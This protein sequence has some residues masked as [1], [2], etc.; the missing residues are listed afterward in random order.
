MQKC[1]GQ[2]SHCAKGLPDESKLSIITKEEHV[3]AKPECI[4]AL[5]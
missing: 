5:G 4:A 3:L 1:M 2:R